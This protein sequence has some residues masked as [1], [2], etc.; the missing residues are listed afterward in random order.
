MSKKIVKYLPKG[1]FDSLRRA[2]AKINCEPVSR[3]FAAACAIVSTIGILTV[4][5]GK[6]SKKRK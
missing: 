1:N 4:I 3:S 2:G 5:A 6:T